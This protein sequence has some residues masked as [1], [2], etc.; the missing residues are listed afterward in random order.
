MQ[1]NLILNKPQLAKFN[2]QKPFQLTAAQLQASGTPNALLKFNN[3]KA[4]KKYARTFTAKKGFRFSPADYGVPSDGMEGGSLDRP[5]SIPSSM[6]E[7]DIEGGSLKK[8][9]RRAKKTVKKTGNSALN[10]ASA[11]VKREANA[12]VKSGR[13]E[14]NSVIKKGKAQA[15]KELKNAKKE[16]IKTLREAKEVGKTTLKTGVSTAIGAATTAVLTPIVGPVA[17]P[18]AG[19][20]VANY[21]SAPINKK[22]DGL[23]LKVVR[24]RGRPKKVNNGSN[25]FADGIDIPSPKQ[26]YRAKKLMQGSGFLNV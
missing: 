1:I 25:I 17:A 8:L 16:G 12:L 26:S 7:A 18:M 22:I 23:G 13:A 11:Q 15:N 9:F 3:V 2:K 4:F 19:A 5:T 10:K 21:A 14:A 24:G 20:V 6:N